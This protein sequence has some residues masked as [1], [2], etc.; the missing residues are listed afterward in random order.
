M[1]Y[2]KNKHIIHRHKWV[3]AHWHSETKPNPE[4]CNNCSSMCASLLPP[5]NHHNSDA[6]Y[7]RRGNQQH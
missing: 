4:N 1:Q 3:Y 2:D 5:D 6:V 7:Q